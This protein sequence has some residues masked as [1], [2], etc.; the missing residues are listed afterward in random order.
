MRRKLTRILSGL[1]AFAM[2]MSYSIVL[3]GADAEAGS[4]KGVSKVSITNVQGKKIT[5]GK[6]KKLK[7]KAEVVLK[8]GSKA[9]KKVTYK[10]SDTS[11][12]K[13]SKS[14]VIKAKKLGKAKVTVQSK[15]NA[16]KKVTITVTVAKKNLMIKKISLRK[17]LTLH[18]P[19]VEDDA[20]EDDVSDS[21]DEDAEDVEED[22]E[23][24]EDDEDDDDDD[25]EITYSLNAKVSPSNASNQNLKWTSSNKGVVTVDQDGEITVV[26]AGKAVITAKATDGSKKKA[27]CKVTV[28][29]DADGEDD[30]DDDSEE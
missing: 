9:S 17:S 8:K 2:M 23:E 7:L 29:D 25:D 27:T 1:L 19:V 22:D 3:S 14:G 26:D 16:K 20:D 4:N 10:S 6:G 12:V 28:I 15:A 21:D 13:V 24:D 11:V 5:L 18:M 30:E